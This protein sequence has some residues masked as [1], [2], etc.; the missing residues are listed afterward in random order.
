MPIRRRTLL[1]S[2][3]LPHAAQLPAN[4]SARPRLFLT[5][6][7]IQEAAKTFFNV[8]NYARFVLLPENGPTKP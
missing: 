6:A 2:L 7:R 4:T 3:I 8:N 5:A 1:Q